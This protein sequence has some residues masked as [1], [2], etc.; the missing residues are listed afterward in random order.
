LANL[1]IRIVQDPILRS[2]LDRVASKT[3]IEFHDMNSA[4]AL[5]EENIPTMIIFEIEMGNAIEYISK[6]KEKWPR[7]FLQAMLTPSSYHG[8][9]YLFWKQHG[10]NNFAILHFERYE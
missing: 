5:P 10:P 8:T 4:S 2:Y 6:W 7:C 1:F 3:G 9:Q